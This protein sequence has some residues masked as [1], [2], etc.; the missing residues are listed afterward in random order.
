MES[1]RVTQAGKFNPEKFVS[2]V[3]LRQIRYFVAAAECGKVS[4]AASIMAIS[5][6]AI[7]EAIAELEALSRSKLF[8]RHPRGLTLT[9]EGH[10][11]L[12]Y[13]RNILSSVRDASY[14]FGEPSLSAEGSFT[15]ATTST[16]TGYFLA[17]LLARFRKSF[18]N[19]E[20]KLVEDSR[21][22]LE[23]G[24]LSSDYDSAILVVSNV[25]EKSPLNRLTLL[26]SMR[27]LWFA[28]GHPLQEHDSISLRKI[29][30]YPYIQLTIDGAEESTAAYW[31]KYGLEPNIILRT[32]S[33]EAVRSLIALG[34]GVTILSDLMYRQWSL[35]GS[36]IEACEITDG[37][38][39]M[40]VGLI[41]KG[42]K[43]E[44][45]TTAAFISFC[46]MEY[47]YLAAFRP[48]AT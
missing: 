19:I 31:K 40:N 39:T 32:E 12:I 28:P 48:P 22:N 18:P 23:E 25:A 6:S 46:Q 11:F 2:A 5:P 14:A 4:L 34:H 8:T 20:V 26:H 47:S 30:G 44:N 45:S 9:Y 10:R 24:V 27:R 1:Q 38:P 7:T 36:R 3:T 33:V 37:I 21:N 42:K 35:E 41:W 13:C 16:I 43:N 29:S 15:L 17:P